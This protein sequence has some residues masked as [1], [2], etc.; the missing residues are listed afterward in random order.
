MLNLELAPGSV[1]LGD[2]ATITQV[3]MN[4][5]T[6]ASDALAAQVGKI[7][8]RTKRVSELDARWDYALG[9]R[10]GAGNWLLIEVSDNGVGM[11]EATRLR[12]FEPFLSTK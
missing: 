3:M 4:L 8:V 12:V 5:L 1:V 6:N 2:R 7:E 9:A 11:D 10:V